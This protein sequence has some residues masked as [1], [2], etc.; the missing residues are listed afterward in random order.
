MSRASPRHLLLSI[1]TAV[2][3][4]LNAEVSPRYLNWNSKAK[5]YAGLV[6]WINVYHRSSKIRSFPNTTTDH[7]D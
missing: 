3:N 2:M 7:L 6:F 1:L 4:I 5:V